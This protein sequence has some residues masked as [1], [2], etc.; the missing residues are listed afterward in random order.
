MFCSPNALLYRKITKCPKTF[1]RD[2]S[3]DFIAIL[4]QFVI[5]NVYSIQT[6]I[7]LCNL[8]VYT[9]IQNKSC[10]PAKK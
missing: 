10:V 8:S 1:G 3:C 4:V 7:R 5:V 9:S 6:S 2:C